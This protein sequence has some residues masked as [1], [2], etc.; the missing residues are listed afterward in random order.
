MGLYLERRCNERAMGTGRRP[1]AQG[2]SRIARAQVEIPKFRNYVPTGMA[3]IVFR[4]NK[5]SEVVGTRQADRKQLETCFTALSA[6]RP[7]S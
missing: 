6:N 1:E 7:Y 5:V 2:R 3:N 4:W